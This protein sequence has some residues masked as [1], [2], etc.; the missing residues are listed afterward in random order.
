[1]AHKAIGEHVEGQ[2][3]GYSNLGTNPEN[4]DSFPESSIH[5]TLYKKAS[6]F[7]NIHYYRNET[8]MRKRNQQEDEVTRNKNGS[9]PPA[10]T[11]E[12]HAIS[13]FLQIVKFT[14]KI[15]ARKYSRKDVW[16]GLS[17]TTVKIKALNQKET[18]TFLMKEGD[19]DVDGFAEAMYENVSP[20]G[21]EE[22]ESM[23]VE[24]PEAFYGNTNM[25]DDSDKLNEA[26]VQANTPSGNVADRRDVEIATG[27]RT[28]I[29]IRRAAMNEIVCWRRK[30]YISCAIAALREK[31]GKGN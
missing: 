5:V 11:T 14:T 1:M 19:F 15:P 20:S 18:H 2:Q 3:P 23:D 6:Q 27:K 22:E 29:K 24:L 31:R 13:E 7:V 4:K 17:K 28:S 9:M 12:H 21:T 8:E 16:D 25:I 10:R 26:I 30:I